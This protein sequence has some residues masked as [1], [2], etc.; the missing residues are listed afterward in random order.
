LSAATADPKPI[1][2]LRA[3]A[4]VL[5]S[6]ADTWLSA[7]TLCW[8]CTLP[9][10]KRV[11]PLPRLVRLMWVPAQDRDRQLERELRMAKVVRRLC[12]TSGGN[13]LER[14]LILYRYLARA[15]ADPQLVVGMAKPDEYL[16]H[17]W[18][19]LDG[20]PLLETAETL[21][22]YTEVVR[23]GRGGAQEP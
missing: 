13:C 17:V 20:R 16:G 4:S 9:I 22:T 10:L 18:V 12:R 21:R 1:S 8:M 23:F 14:S 3:L 11:L 6:P 5:R 2:R 15:N 7:R 19:M